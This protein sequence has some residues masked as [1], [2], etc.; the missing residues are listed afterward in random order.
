VV[1]YNNGNEIS[2]EIIEK[3]AMTKVFTGN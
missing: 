1:N 2:E 3:A